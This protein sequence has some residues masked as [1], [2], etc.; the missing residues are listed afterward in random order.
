MDDTLRPL[1]EAFSQTLAPNPVSA[2]PRR[3]PVR[4]AMLGEDR[5]LS[6]RSS[7]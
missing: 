1:L 7:P 3:W 5:Q 2:E 4:Q 6:S